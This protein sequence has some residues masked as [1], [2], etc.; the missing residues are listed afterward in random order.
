MEGMMEPIIT[1]E[2]FHPNNSNPV[3]KY[4]RSVLSPEQARAVGQNLGPCR[5]MNAID[6]MAKL[7]RTNLT[8]DDM[9][10]VL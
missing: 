1:T 7:A 8:S 9:L 10:V 4:E 5:K 6:W 3:V 2:V